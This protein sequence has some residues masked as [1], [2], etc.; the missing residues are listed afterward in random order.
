M[1]T[2]VV[3]YALCPEV[4]IDEIVRQC[5]AAIAW[6]YAHATHFNGD[7]DRIYVEG[8][9]AGAHLTAMAILTA[10]ESDYALPADH[11]KGGCGISGLYRPGTLALY[12]CAVVVATDG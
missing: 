4:D 3:N 12:F 8:H 10:W 7:P 9:S 5:R 6:T 2:V 1:T 11:I